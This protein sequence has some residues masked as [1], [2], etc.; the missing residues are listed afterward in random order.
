MLSVYH[1]LKQTTVA[2][3]CP[4]FIIFSEAEGRQVVLRGQIIYYKLDF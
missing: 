3:V 1:L 4:V 2:I